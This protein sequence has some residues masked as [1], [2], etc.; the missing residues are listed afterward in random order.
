M[1]PCNVV[2]SNLL[3]SSQ[4]KSSQVKSSQVKSSQVKSS[5]VK[6]SHKNCRLE[7]ESPTH[8]LRP[9][10]QVAVHSFRWLYYEYDNSIYYVVILTMEEGTSFLHVLT[11]DYYWVVSIEHLLLFTYIL[12]ENQ[13]LYSLTIFYR[14]LCS[15]QY[16]VNESIHTDRR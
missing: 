3:K 13:L 14:R 16:I 5:Q 6:S 11:N 1:I 15:I 7:S 9:W 12:P 10:T 2:K 8:I 4:V